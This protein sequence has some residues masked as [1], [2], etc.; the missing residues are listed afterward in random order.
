MSLTLLAFLATGC[1]AGFLAGLLGVGGGL[2]IVPALIWVFE[3]HGFPPQHTLHLALGTSLASIVFTSLSSVRAHHGRGA[4]QWATVKR[5]GL[6]L[7]LGTFAGSWLAAQVDSLWLKWF[8]VA[9]A[10]LVAAQMLSGY[11]PKP[12]RQLPG[13]AGLSTAGGL[14]GGVS[15]FVG[16]GGGSLSVP[17]MS[18]CNVPLQTA[19]G[20][21]AALGFPIAVGGLL[22]YAVNGAGLDHLPPWS[23]GFVYLPALAGIVVASVLMA[24]LGAAVAH[25]LP[26]AT[27][28][29]CFAALLIIIASKMLLGLL[30]Y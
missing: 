26:V 10:Y 24:P 8:F 23:L 7:A 2:I 4:V 19:V 18:W 6:G 12:S 25:R 27:L 13:A 30:G 17:F 1:A 15:A 11:K 22:G 20:T 16:I 9:F 28:K 21:S 29:K 14:I 3:Q 5:M